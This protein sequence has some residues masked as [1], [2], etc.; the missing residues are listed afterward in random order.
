MWLPQL[1]SAVPFS[2]RR[3]HNHLINCISLVVLEVPVVSVLKVG[4]KVRTRIAEVSDVGE[5]L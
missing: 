1:C 4:V 5:K 3:S 2:G